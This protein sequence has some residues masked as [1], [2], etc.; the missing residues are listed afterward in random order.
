MAE[1]ALGAN[2]EF[3]QGIVLKMLPAAFRLADDA[4]LQDLL[5][6]SGDIRA[7]LNSMSIMFD[8]L[9]AGGREFEAFLLGKR[10][11]LMAER[12][13]A[14]GT[15]VRG[16]SLGSCCL[17]HSSSRVMRSV[18]ICW[19]WPSAWA[20]ADEHLLQVLLT[21]GATKAALRIVRRK[22][23]LMEREQNHVRRARAA[24]GPRRPS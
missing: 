21:H 18:R 1:R 5:S 20:A 9:V 12:L 19:P 14:P 6:K 24:D 3:T 10:I 15:S 2:D 16:T 7:A 11:A 4:E 17:Q 23:V 22:L 8:S 13:L